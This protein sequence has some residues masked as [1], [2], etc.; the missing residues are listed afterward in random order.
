MS[1]ALTNTNEKNHLSYFFR[2]YVFGS[3]GVDIRGVCFNYGILSYCHLR[4]TFSLVSDRLGGQVSTQK[5]VG[6]LDKLKMP[7]KKWQSCSSAF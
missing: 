2:R 3:L 5:D 1:A 6:T 4:P 7:N